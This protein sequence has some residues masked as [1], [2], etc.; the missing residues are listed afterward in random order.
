M[1]EWGCG[2]AEHESTDLKY[3]GVPNAM[4]MQQWAK[5]GAKYC[6]FRGCKR[7]VWGRPLCLQDTQSVEKGSR[8]H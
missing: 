2:D 8:A 1:S 3:F 5:R 4:L 6:Q 7:C